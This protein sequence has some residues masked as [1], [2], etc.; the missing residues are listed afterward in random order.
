MDNSKK[1]EAKEL[2]KKMKDNFD[3]SLLEEWIKDNKL[4]FKH[5]EIIY[6][7]RPLTMLE[8]EEIN[9]L[10]SQEFGRLMIDKNI[11]TEKMI[12]KNYKEKGL[13]LEELD[14]DMK[15]LEN[16]KRSADLKLGEAIAKKVDEAVWKVYE[17]QIN[18]IKE[19]LFLLSLEKS[20]YLSYS[21]ES[22]LKNFSAKC[23]SFMSLDKKTEENWGR[24]FQS[25]NDFNKCEDEELKEKAV[26]YSIMLNYGR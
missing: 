20:A 9:R 1:E 16:D 18:E 25:M 13:D 21:L 22:C 6:R 10:T 15:K 19:K 5:K 14:S 2:L 23:I 12:I 4:E 8:K 24:V 11:L 7:V 17:E 26:Y 3:L